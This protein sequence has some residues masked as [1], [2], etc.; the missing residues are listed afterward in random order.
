LKKGEGGTAQKKP[1]H[2]PKEGFSSLR[3]ERRGLSQVG[4][5]N[6]GAGEKKK[7]EKSW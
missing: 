5:E 6:C 7:G 3:S 1:K 4:T 2:L